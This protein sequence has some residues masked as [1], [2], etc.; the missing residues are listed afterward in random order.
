MV[1]INFL[2]PWQSSRTPNSLICELISCKREPLE[3]CRCHKVLN[4]NI[5][6]LR[7]LPTYF[8]ILRPDSFARSC[9]LSSDKCSALLKSRCVKFCSLCNPSKSSTMTQ[10]ICRKPRLHTLTN[11]VETLSISVANGASLCGG[12]KVLTVRVAHQDQWRLTRRRAFIIFNLIFSSNLSSSRHHIPL[13][14]MSSGS[15]SGSECS[16]IALTTSSRPTGRWNQLPS[17]CFSYSGAQRNSSD[18]LVQ[19]TA[20]LLAFSSTMYLV[21]SKP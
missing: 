13:S 20:L 1:Q 5:C 8:K 14:T 4:S 11:T 16:S 19:W 15:I 2:N 18:R 21:G 6:R 7:G 10:C 17:A 12:R 9:K 3:R